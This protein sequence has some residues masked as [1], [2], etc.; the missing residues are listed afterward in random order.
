MRF[1]LALSIIL[2][3]IVI[4]AILVKLF[5]S[6]FVQTV[7]L[8]IL[9]LS[10]GRTSIWLL[11]WTLSL[12]NLRE[13][14]FD[15]TTGLRNLL[16][17]LG[18][19]GWNLRIRHTCLLHDSSDH[20]LQLTLTLSGNGRQHII[21]IELTL[22]LLNIGHLI[23]IRRTRILNEGLRRNELLLL[24]LTIVIHLGGLT[25]DM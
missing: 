14:L 5:L 25:L 18:L 22:V 12:I 23:V 9:V 4:V 16:L 3:M 15:R 19:L 1:G 21:N 20:V 6:S 7:H 17:I 11:S 8:L 13:I 10:I 24:L 2:L